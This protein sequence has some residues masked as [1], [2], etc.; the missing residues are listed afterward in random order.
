MSGA[1]SCAS[2][3]AARTMRNKPAIVVLGCTTTRGDRSTDGAPRRNSGWRVAIEHSQNINEGD[4]K[5]YGPIKFALLFESSVIPLGA[6]QTKLPPVAGTK[7][8]YK[9]HIQ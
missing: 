2:C 1:D 9:Q 5:A 3:K 6:T 7:V 4:H 8:D